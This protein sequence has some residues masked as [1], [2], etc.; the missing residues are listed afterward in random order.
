[1]WRQ[2]PA[3]VPRSGWPPRCDR[4]Q[5]EQRRPPVEFLAEHAATIR[6]LAAVCQLLHASAFAGGPCPAE[7]PPV[8]AS[9]AN[10]SAAAFR[11]GPAGEWSC[12]LREP[13][14]R[15]AAVGRRV[16]GRHSFSRPA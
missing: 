10:E 8:A 3:S 4:A 11:A 2:P 7:A 16:L 9:A 1:M 5:A 15:E 6:A 14:P 13:L 12:F